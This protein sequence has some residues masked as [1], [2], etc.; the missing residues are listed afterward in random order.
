VPRPL[1]EALSALSERLEPAST[2][3]S[4]QRLWPSVVG[5]AVARVARPIGEHE[6]VLRV[7]CDDAVWAAELELMG[8]SLVRALNTAMGREALVGMRVRADG[9][10]GA[11]GGR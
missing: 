2:L 5:D 8:P 11:P 3:G 9:A 1:G 10:R 4:V 6:G 7:A